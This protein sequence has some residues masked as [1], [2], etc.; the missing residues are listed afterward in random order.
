[1]YASAAQL[2]T[3]YSAEEIA[4]RADASV[5]PVVYGELL[6]AAANGA[7]LSAYSAEEQ[8][9][10]QAAL[11]RVERALEDARQTINSY[12]GGRYQLPLSNAPQVLERIAGQ[13]AR[14]VLYDDS[15]TEQ[16]TTL[17]K[18]S[19]K[20]LESVANGRVQ[21]GPTDSGATVQPSAGAEMV[22]SG[23]VFGRDSSRGYI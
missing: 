18:D 10:A 22:S 3:R 8:A 6:S 5:P 23:L 14:F 21:L 12:L 11:A 9:A 16:V 7:D 1:M 17:Y 15:A 19:I 13:I 20:F 4:Q 2:L